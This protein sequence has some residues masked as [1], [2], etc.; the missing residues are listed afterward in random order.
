MKR[1]VERDEQRVRQLRESIE[2][3]KKRIRELEDEEILSDLNTISA[4]GVSAGKIV[5]AIKNKDAETLFRLI[6]QE[7]AKESTGDFNA[8][9][10]NTK[11]VMS[12]EQSV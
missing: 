8:G 12:N 4:R 7:D 9:A 1:S 10:Q 5:E 3:R 6:G 11:E 2:A